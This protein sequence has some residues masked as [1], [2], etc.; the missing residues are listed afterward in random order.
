MITSLD[1]KSVTLAPLE[2]RPISVTGSVFSCLTS[3]VQFLASFDG[4]P[5]IPLQGG[6]QID[7]R[8][9]LFKS[10]IV[11]NRTNAPLTLTFYCGTCMVTYSPVTVQTV[12]SDAPTYPKGYDEQALGGGQAI[13]FTG[14]DRGHSRKQ[15]IIHNLDAANKLQL[16]DA[17]DGNAFLDILAG[18]T[19]TVGLSGP[20]WLY[21]PSGGPIT[22]C[23][24]ELFYA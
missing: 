11:Q 17:N 19:K 10:V 23:A 2:I 7:N 16:L 18:E 24:G 20:C 6:L 9:N 13:A 14:V 8:P 12:T 3:T 22:Y 5:Y 15:I 21:N 4:G 1:Y